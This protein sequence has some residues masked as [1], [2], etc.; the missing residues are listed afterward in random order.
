MPPLKTYLNINKKITLNQPTIDYIRRTY[1]V[2]A[3]LKQYFSD[4]LLKIDN[5]KLLQHSRMSNGA[6]AILSSLRKT[7]KSL[8]SPKMYRKPNVLEKNPK[9]RR[10]NLQQILS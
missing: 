4:E 3:G 7:S 9:N 2:N 1:Q 5:A 10:K 6:V 8:P